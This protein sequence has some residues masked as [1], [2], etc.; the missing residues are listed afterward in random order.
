MRAVGDERLACKG[1]AIRYSRLSGVWRADDGGVC[2]E[3]EEGEKEE[4]VD[5]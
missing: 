2:R 4:F 3:G 1:C 5:D